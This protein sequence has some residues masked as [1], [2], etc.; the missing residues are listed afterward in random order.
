[1][2]DFNI[3]P[4]GEIGYI[5]KFN[6]GYSLYILCRAISIQRMSDNSIKDI[7]IKKHGK[8]IIDDDIHANLPFKDFGIK[9]DWEQIEEVMTEM[10]RFINE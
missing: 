1:M 4:N 8:V 10:E 9:Y 6:K 3:Q 7:C 2:Y 5:K